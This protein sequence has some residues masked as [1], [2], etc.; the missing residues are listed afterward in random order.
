[1]CAELE[2]GE[3]FAPDDKSLTDLL[4]ILSQHFH[5]IVL[6]LPSGGGTLA[7][8]AFTNASLACVVSDRSVHSARTLTRLMHHIQGRLRPPTTHIVMNQSRAPARGAVHARDFTEALEW[9]VAVNIAFDGQ[10]PLMAE[11]LGDPLPARSEFGRG[12]KML[13]G[14]LTGEGT[15]SGKYAPGMGGTSSSLFARLRGA[16]P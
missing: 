13:A 15:T 8:E 16:R 14:L 12:I 10:A 4:N 6:D 11:N 7:N 2:Y 5:Y 3:A 1:L 9:P